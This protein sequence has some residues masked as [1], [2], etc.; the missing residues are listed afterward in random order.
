MVIFVLVV[1]IEKMLISHVS[2]VNQLLLFFQA[3]SANMLIKQICTGTV[4][5]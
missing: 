2:I 5:V 4:I 3:H 1:E